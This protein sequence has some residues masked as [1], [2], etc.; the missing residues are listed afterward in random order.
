MKI[1]TKTL[2]VLFVFV[3]AC[4]SAPAWISDII[5]SPQHYEKTEILVEGYL[6]V[7][8][9]TVYISTV[10][11][12]EQFDTGRRVILVVDE[13]MYRMLTKVKNG[14]MIAVSGIFEAPPPDAI[15]M[16]TGVLLGSHIKVLRIVH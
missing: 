10:N 6:C 14:S 3:S 16:P 5:Q 11:A 8:G 13:P 2:C 15:I 9:T 12:C 7:D 1:F 4:A